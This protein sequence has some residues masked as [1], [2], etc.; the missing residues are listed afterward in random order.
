MLRHCTYSKQV[1][2]LCQNKM[3]STC[4]VPLH[5]FKAS[6]KS[7]KL[8]SSYGGHMY[9]TWIT[10]DNV[11]RVV[12]PKAGI[13]ELQFFSLQIVSWWNKFAL[14]FKKISNS[15]QVTEWTQLYYRNH[16]FQSLKG[17]N[18]KSVLTRVTVLLFCTL[19]H[20]VLHLCEVSTNFWNGF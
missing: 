18:S 12:T 6:R 1:S 20:D 3:C 7:L 2:L 10:I 4:Y 11:Q 16:Y 5:F 13:S 15:F 17:H 14:S 9:M 8:S 19:C